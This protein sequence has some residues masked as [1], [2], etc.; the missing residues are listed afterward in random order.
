MVMFAVMEDVIT[1]TK[2][3][4][5]KRERE[6][7]REKRERVKWKF[8]GSLQRDRGVFTLSKDDDG[9]EEKGG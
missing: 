5:R 4:K 6:E 7:R 2:F 8:K 9:G 3:L 1:V